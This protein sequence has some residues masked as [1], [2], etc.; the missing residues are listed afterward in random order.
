MNRRLL[1]TL[2]VLAACGTVFSL[3]ALFAG[4]R[5]MHA[6]VDE[7][8]PL[9]WMLLAHPAVLA[10]EVMQFKAVPPESVASLERP[11]APRPA[12]PLTAVPGPPA[13]PA[14]PAVLVITRPW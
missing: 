9:A 7:R 4:S 12:A 3:G 8:D 5:A 2:V 10:Q 14:P 11:R 1:A 6:G 13:A